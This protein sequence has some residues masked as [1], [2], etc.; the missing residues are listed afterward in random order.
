MRT[1]TIKGREI[2]VRSLT[3][4]EVRDMKDLGFGSAMFIPDVKTISEAWD[5]ALS[6]VLPKEDLTYLDDLPNK[7]SKPVWEAILAETY[8]A[9]EEE[10]NLPGTS[11][12]MQTGNE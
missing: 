2:M 1:V 10:K 5:T 6:T 4:R 7:E 12:G 3:R 8:G 11:D 9:E